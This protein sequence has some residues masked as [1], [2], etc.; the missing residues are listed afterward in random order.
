MVIWPLVAR[1]APIAST[2]ICKSSTEMVTVRSTMVDRNAAEAILFRVSSLR[3]LK[4]PNIRR[5]RL[6]A[7]ITACAAT[8][9]CTMPS[10]ADSFSFC[11]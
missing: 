5:C 8:F 9:S 3:N 11:S 10:S 1:Y 7:L 4:K 6:K 2:T